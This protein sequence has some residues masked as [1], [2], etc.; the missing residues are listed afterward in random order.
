[1]DI[2]IYNT[3]TRRK[4]K[5]TPL[6]EKTVKIYTC[7]QTTYNDIHIGNARFYV[8]FDTVRRY[9]EHCGYV[10]QFVQNFTDIDDRIIARA[11]EEQCECHEI[12]QKY[13]ART[14]EDLK[15]LNVAPATHN[16][17]ATQEMP[18]IIDMVNELVQ[19]GAAYER[20]GTV[21]FDTSTRPDYGKLSRKKPEDLISGHRIAANTDKKSPSDIVLWNPAK[22]GEP[23]WESPWGAGRPGWHIECSAMAK[24]YLGE[25]IDIH[26]GAADLIFPHHE[27]EIAQTESLTN[28]PFANYWMHCGLITVAH[29]KM[30]K[31]LGNFQT[32]RQVAERF[33]H[34]VI[35]F[36]LL[37]GHYRMPMEFG[38]E[39]IKAAGRGLE[40]VRN[41]AYALAAAREVPVAHGVSAAGGE[42]SRFAG[43]QDNASHSIARIAP[44][45]TSPPAAAQGVDSGFGSAADVG[46]TGAQAPDTAVHI[47]DFHAAMC[48]DFNTADAVTAIFE[49]VKTVN[50]AL[51]QAGGIEEQVARG[52]LDELA[53]M[54]GLLGLDILQGQSGAEGEIEALIAA[55]QSARV[56]RNFAEA[57]RIRSELSGMGIIL[58]DTPGGVRWKRA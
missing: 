41:C 37:S 28:A 17:C 39:M 23:A 36:Y 8:I 54:C 40:R 19:K 42:A 16:P 34:E 10:V 11:L 48:D 57:D 26:G 7:G 29:K 44:A 13:I 51:A 50:V 46:S 49:W 2:Q 47:R 20:G 56:E 6:E 5:F 25:R 55:R 43:S 21:Y 18:Q 52:L 58:E 14:Q 15:N 38:D 33:N 24:K 32:L 35:R 30:S 9:L 4:E 45:R 22:P 53:Q 3:L 1:M 12:S 31:S 27:N